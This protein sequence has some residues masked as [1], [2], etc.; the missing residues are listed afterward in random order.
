[1]VFAPH[2]TITLQDEAKTEVHFL[3]NNWTLKLICKKLNCELW[4]FQNR[5]LK[6]AGNSEGLEEVKPL[7]SED[8][9]VI[10]LAANESFCQYNK[11]PFTSTEIDA[12]AWIDALGG[13]ING[14]FVPFFT[15]FFSRIFNIDE[16]KTVV[17]KKAEPPME[18]A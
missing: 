7:G 16:S 17:E 5:I 2:Y 12:S 8:V 11:T 3:F 13:S 18:V 14:D 6:T 10:M 9:E 4:E 1:M 15:A